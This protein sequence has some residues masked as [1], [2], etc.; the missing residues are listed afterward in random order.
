VA[1][2]LRVEAVAEDGVVEALSV[3][4]A[5]TF[6]VGVQFHPEWD[7]AGNRLYAAL[8]AAFREAVWQRAA[9]RGLRA[10]D[11]DAQRAGKAGAT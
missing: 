7:V 4:G 11:H 6:A 10:A 9:Q 5:S 8:F 3:E 1:Q 2:G